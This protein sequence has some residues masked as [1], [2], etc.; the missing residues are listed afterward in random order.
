MDSL[1]PNDPQQPLDSNNPYPPPPPI[2]N[3]PPPAPGNAA[4]P[5]PPGGSPA[6]SASSMPGPDASGVTK[7]ERNWAMFAHL[8]ALAAGLIS[9]ILHVPFFAFLAPLIIWLIKKDESA[10]IAD[11]AKE[12]LNF[13]ISLGILFFGMFIIGLV[14]VW[15][16]V[17]PFIMYFAGIALGIVALV[18][19]VIAAIKASEGKWYRYPFTLRLIK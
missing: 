7:D 6:Y 2:F 14:L 17:V 9:G 5:P 8:S 19:I 15:T 13:T 12:A 4:P 16:I 18:L 1:N 11:Q 3:D 10:F